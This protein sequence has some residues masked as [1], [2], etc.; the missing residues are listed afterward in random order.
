MLPDI[1]ARNA[2]IDAIKMVPLLSLSLKAQY[3]G[4]SPW[5]SWLCTTGAEDW[6]FSASIMLK[7]GILLIPLGAGDGLKSVLKGMFC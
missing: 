6:D 5:V 1:G 4:A 3:A 2:I 7:M